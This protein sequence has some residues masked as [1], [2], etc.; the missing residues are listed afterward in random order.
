[1]NTR[2]DVVRNR[3][4]DGI[5]NKLSNFDLDMQILTT[6]SIRYSLDL[7]FVLSVWALETGWG[8]SSLWIEHNNPAGIKQYGNEYKHFPTKEEGI[9]EMFILLN[10]YCKSGLVTVE[11]IRNI[12][13]V[14]DDSDEIVSIWKMLE[15]V[16]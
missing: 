14:T 10:D 1:M 12:W 3:I 6:L 2:V 15:E 16:N 11:Q 13:S 5:V 7:G 9:K 8:E 4:S